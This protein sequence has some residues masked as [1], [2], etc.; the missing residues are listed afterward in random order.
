MAKRLPRLSQTTPPMVGLSS[1]LILHQQ[2]QL[3]SCPASTSVFRDPSHRELSESDLIDL[4]GCYHKGLYRLHHTWIAPMR[5]I[6][7]W[8]QQRMTTPSEDSAGLS[9]C[10][11]ALPG[12][13]KAMSVIKRPMKVVDFLKRVTPLSGP[14]D[15]TRSLQK[16]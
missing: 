4:L 11:H 5:S 10:F 9:F 8:L 6:V 2:H 15:E 12:L 13:L 1:P 16:K 14:S 3:S 7:L